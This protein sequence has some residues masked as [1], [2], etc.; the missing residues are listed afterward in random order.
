M[1]NE[2]FTDLPTVA[3][4]SPTDI[5][6]AVQGYVSTL[7]PGTSVQQTLQ[8]VLNLGLSNTILNHAGN[9]N[10]SIAGVTYQLLWD[11][12]D[13]VL[14][15]CTTSGNASTAVWKP[16]VG[17][18]TNGQ[19]LIGSTGAAPVAATLTAGANISITNGAGNI[20]IAAT[21]PGGFVWTRVTGTS[22]T[23]VSNNGYIADNA[24]LVTL[25]LPATS[26]I[27]DELIIVGRGA[28]GWSISQ[29]ASQ[30]I[31]I[32]HTSST[33]GVGG[34]V[35]S[36]NRRDGVYLVCTNT[37]LEWTAATGPEGNLTIV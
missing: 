33:V 30:Q 10:T 16:V 24:G 14:W 34:S 22:Q 7:N 5:I 35:A 31:I 36:S 37:N 4:A 29:A 17:Q 11:S 26:A 6:C 8:Q 20:T 3:N 15:V 27:G 1:A 2:K 13:N 18:L 32:G 12:T 9:P 19:L 21:G 28:G 25:A 23:M